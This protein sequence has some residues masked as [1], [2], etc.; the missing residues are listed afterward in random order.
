M[1]SLPMILEPDTLHQHLHDENL[2]LVDLSGPEHY[3]EAHIPGAIHVHPRETR[4]AASPVPG[5][6][7][8]K[9]ELEQL[10]GR[11]GLKPEHHVVAYDDEGGGWAGRFIWL[12]ESVGHRNWSLLNGGRIAWIRE[13]Y[14]TS[15]EVS[16]AT[17][18]SRP[19]LTLDPSTTADL[20]E[21]LE[22]VRAGNTAIWDARAPAE[23]RGERQSAARSGHIPGAVNLEWTEIMDPER[24]YRLL[25]EDRLRETLTSLGIEPSKP[26]ITHCQSHHRS[27]LTYVAA[28]ALGYHDV[29]AYAGSWAEWGNRTETPVE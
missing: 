25:P 1:P 23:Y 18:S 15:T 29:R 9:A 10:L 5:L 6:L 4:G 20:E 28:R 19:A 26:V 21:V 13:G 2:L 17:E 11:I 16:E 3:T 7:P 22:A 12:L 14:P 8:E 24:N 27:G